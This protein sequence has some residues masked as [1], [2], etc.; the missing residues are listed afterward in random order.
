MAH[1]FNRV[2]NAPRFVS[3]ISNTKFQIEQARPAGHAVKRANANRV[4]Y[5]QPESG[6]TLPLRHQDSVHDNLAI[7]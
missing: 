4:Q 5:K 6:I 2:G 1:S 7:V 3:Q